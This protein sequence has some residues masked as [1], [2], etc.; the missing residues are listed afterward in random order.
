MTSY[1]SIYRTWQS[2][3]S[4]KSPTPSLDTFEYDLESNLTQLAKDL[5]NDNYHHGPYQHITITEKKR[6]DLSVAT[7][8]DRIVHRLV[9]DRLQPIFDHRLD[10]DVWSCRRGKGLHGALRRTQQLLISH[11]HSHIWRLDVTKFFDSV[12]RHVLIACL[13]R[14]IPDQQLLALCT[15]I[16]QS[17][18]P[19][20]PI[21][22]LTS[23]I[24]AN[25]YLHEF[26]RFVRHHLRP[27]AYVRYGDDS[28]IF[29]R[30]RREALSY[31]RLGTDF[32][33]TTL[34]LRVNPR[35]DVIATAHT[36]LHFLGHAITKNWIVVDRHTTQ[37]ATE[38][39]NLTN[40]ASYQSLKLAKYPKK[41][42]SWTVL[43]EI[44]G[45]TTIGVK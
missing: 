41:G 36:G 37:R 23:Q 1:Q 11:P 34:K 44:E 12:D 15:G 3:R 8:R 7:V 26:D 40:I 9:Y 27:L 22:N 33:R 17:F 6:R 38:R 28:I 30:T 45:V 20:I 13:S 42:L 31:Q 5:T 14:T 2:F 32:L 4:G 24:F 39:V 29:A 25:I 10:P 18:A 19:G 21:G 35:N 43:D 16:I